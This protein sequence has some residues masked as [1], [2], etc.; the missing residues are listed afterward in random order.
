MLLAAKSFVRVAVLG[1]NEERRAT[2]V[3]GLV[4]SGSGGKEMLGD[5]RVTFLGCHE[6][7]RVTI[8]RCLVNAGLGETD[9]AVG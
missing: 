5:F 8:V 3:V 4:H 9:F 6:E 2:I 7:R 1:C